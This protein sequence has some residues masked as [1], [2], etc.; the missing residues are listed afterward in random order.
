MFRRRQ[1][2]LKL[3]NPQLVFFIEIKLDDRRMEIIRRK[4][5]FGNDFRVTVIGSRGGLCLAWKI[6]VKVDLRRFLVNHMDTLV[7][8]EDDQGKWHFTGFYGSLVTN[9][10]SGSWELLKRLGLNNME[11]WFVCEGF[12]E[13]LYASEKK[14]GLPREESQMELFREALQECR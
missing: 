8:M 6:G 4:C 7:E 12:N 9:N 2:M 14:G 11:P 10:I 5:G 1:H 13:I 3:Y